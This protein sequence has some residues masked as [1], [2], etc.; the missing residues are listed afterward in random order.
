MLKNA[1]VL[2]NDG[3]F[4]ADGKSIG[5]MEVP[6]AEGETIVSLT[7]SLAKVYKYDSKYNFEKK[8]IENIF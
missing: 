5:K 2:C 4:M 3:N 6:V 8:L 7:K 1:W